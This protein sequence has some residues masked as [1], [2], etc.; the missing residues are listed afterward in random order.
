MEFDFAAVHTYLNGGTVYA[1]KPKEMPD[2][3]S[4]AAVF[5]YSFGNVLK[6][7]QKWRTI[8]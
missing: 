8:P 5:R 1:L 6:G 3:T 7:E 2:E 4:L